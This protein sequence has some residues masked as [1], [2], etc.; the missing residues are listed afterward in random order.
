MVTMESCMNFFDQMVEPAFESRLTA[1]QR[2]ALPDNAFGLPKERKYPLV[3]KG[4][5]GEYDWSHLRDAIAYF[6]TCKDEE[7]KRELAGNIAKVIKKYK[8][9]IVISDNNKI[10]NYANF[11]KNKP[12][13]A[14][15]SFAEFF[16]QLEI[17]E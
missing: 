7:K 12:E 17:N 8:V 6:H 1:A 2:R 3:I 16:D 10:R 15:E 5:D 11:P 14:S 13:P 4:E 9:D